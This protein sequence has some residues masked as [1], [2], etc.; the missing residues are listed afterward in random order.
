M[1][2]TYSIIYALLM[3]AL[4]SC[5]RQNF[6]A[7]SQVEDDSYWTEKDDERTRGTN[8]KSVE[9]W[10]NKKENRSEPTP[11][12]YN[13]EAPPSSAAPDYEDQRGRQ[14]RQ[15]WESQ[16]YSDNNASQ[17]DNSGLNSQQNLAQDDMEERENERDARRFG[18]NRTVYY[19]D[20]YFQALS[21]N[22]S[23]TSLYAPI[24]RPGFYNWAPGWNV[25]LSWNSFNGFGVG[26]GFGMGMGM[27]MGMQFGYGFGYNPFFFDPWM[28]GGGG[29]G[30]GFHNPW[31]MPMYNPY[32]PWGFNPWYNPYRFGFGCGGFYNPWGFR[33]QHHYGAGRG[34]IVTNRPLMQPRNS[35]GS[36]IPSAVGTNRPNNQIFDGRA[37]RDARPS[38]TQNY[39]GSATPN[40]RPN[41]NIRYSPDRPANSN[42]PSTRPGG[43]LRPDESGRPVYVSPNNN[44]PIRSAE[45]L[46]TQSNRPGGELREGRDGRPVYIP[47]GRSRYDGIESRP[48]NNNERPSRSYDGGNPGRSP[49]SSRPVIE[50]PRNRGGNGGFSTPPPSQSAP[51]RPSYSA[52]AP[53]RPSYSAPSPSSRPSQSAPSSRPPAGGGGM[54]PR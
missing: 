21:P 47:P 48:S 33:N 11:S 12:R 52:P 22:W 18:S 5:S 2:N 10:N 51:S 53:S 19:D 17:E 9:P 36:S 8:I 49:G 13:N 40:A 35:M 3:F 4:A 25:G 15:T 14:A 16:R 20:P 26:S 43:E 1:K 39:N 34:D 50:S 28:Y 30:M 7:I 38:P 37:V 44:N 31:H 6:T 45:P 46:P 32:A 29:W 27:G 24:V 23:W 41:E 54:R 42:S